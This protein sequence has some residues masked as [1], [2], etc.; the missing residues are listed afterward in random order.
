[1]SASDWI[2][3]SVSKVCNVE[4]LSSIKAPE[5]GVLTF[6]ATSVRAGAPGGATNG[7]EPG[8]QWR[9]AWYCLRVRKLRQCSDTNTRERGTIFTKQP[10]SFAGGISISHRND[11][12]PK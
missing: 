11:P 3:P 1:M 2:E 6:R 8:V 9:Q 5:C 12:G 7:Q 10:N 4:P